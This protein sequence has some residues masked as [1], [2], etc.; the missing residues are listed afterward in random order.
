LWAKA[1]LKTALQEEYGSHF[2][3]VESKQYLIVHNCSADAAKEAGRLLNRAHTIFAN[4]F[5]THGGFRLKKPKQPLVAVMFQSRNE[6]VQRMTP[7]LGP[8]A[9]NTSGV[10]SPKS[11]RIYL[12]NHFGGAPFA[13]GLPANKTNK[14]G[15]RFVFNSTGAL[16]QNIMT[17]VH[18]AVHQAAFNTGF[19][20]RS[21][22]DLPLWFLEGMAMFFETPDLEADNGWKGGRT[23][24]RERA[25]HFLGMRGRLRPGFLEEL[26]ANDE[27]LRDPRTALDGYAIAWAVTFFLL[28]T[29][30]ANYMEYARLVNARPPLASYGRADRLAD[31]ER[32]FKRPPRDVEREFQAEI[33]KLL[34]KSR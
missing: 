26:V 8:D 4:Y 32:A 1:D 25:P 11:N 31:F 23:V 29:E 15:P 27:L 13:G 10:Y 9:A 2:K 33:V 19:H 14:P 5:Q 18:E 34:E 28:K 7:T 30:K 21:A 17:V 12:F 3:V 6:Y 20:N 24:S 16:E 22:A